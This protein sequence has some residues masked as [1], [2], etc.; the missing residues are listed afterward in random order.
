[1]IPLDLEGLRASFYTGNCHKW[2]CAPK[3]AGF[4]VVRT[5]YR[6]RMLP[7]T[8]SHGWNEPSP[9][10][11]FHALFDWVGTEDPTARLVVP[12]AIESVAHLSPDGWDG[13]MH[14]NR[15]L[16]LEA[17]TTLCAA[18][19]IDPPAPEEM[20][21]S[22]AALP[23]AN[24]VGEQPWS[25]DPLSV[26]LRQGWNIEVPVYPWPEHPH[27]LIRISAQLYNH[28]AQYRLLAEALLQERTGEQPA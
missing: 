6:D 15:N 3:G 2:L 8:I 1:M 11:R 7:V 21:G 17:R 16:M 5:E 26:R 12:T 27:R 20:I 4:L 10:S 13:V 18:L 28:P 14:S 9:R 25:P 23:L 24:G 19:S 22:M